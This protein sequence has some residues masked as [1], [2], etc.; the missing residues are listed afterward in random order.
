MKKLLLYLAVLLLGTFTSNAAWTLVGTDFSNSNWD[1]D[2][3]YEFTEQS[4]GVYV[5][6][7][8]S[9]GKGLT[10]QFKLR[11]G[12]DWRGANIGTKT[13]TVPIEGSDNLNVK[14]GNSTD[15]IVL[16]WYPND[17]KLDV[18]YKVSTD[19]VKL[20]IDA[21][22]VAASN[23]YLWIWGN[24]NQ[25]GDYNNR[26]S[27]QNV[28][29]GNYPY[30]GD[31]K[32]DITATYN[33]TTKLYELELAPGMNS[34][35]MTVGKDGGQQEYSGTNAIADGKVV[36]VN[37]TAQTVYDY[38]TYLTVEPDPTKTIYIDLNGRNA[39]NVYFGLYEGGNFNGTNL[40]K[41]T[42]W[43][44]KKTLKY[45]IDNASTVQLKNAGDSFA[46]VVLS[47]GRVQLTVPERITSVIFVDNGEY[48]IEGTL[49]DGQNI[50]I[51]YV[52][53]GQTKWYVH[54][55]SFNGWDVNNTGY[56]IEWNEE[57]QAYI[58]DKPEIK[59]QFKISKGSD[60]WGA[61][62][63]DVIVEDGLQITAQ[64]S[65]DKNFQVADG[66][67][68]QKVRITLV[69]TDRSPK[70]TFS[71]Y[72]EVAWPAIQPFL[73]GVQWGW[74]NGQ[75]FKKI[76]ENLY[77]LSGHSMDPNKDFC[78]DATGGNNLLT[79]ANYEGT[80]PGWLKV[81]G[82]NWH[83]EAASAAKY[84]LKIHRTAQNTYTWEIA[85]HVEIPTVIPNDG[86]VKRIFLKY[87]N[88]EQLENVGFWPYSNK[89]G[90]GLDLY[91]N[92]VDYDKATTVY[93]VD[94]LIAQHSLTNSSKDEEGNDL[95]RQRTDFLTVFTLEAD[96]E[97]YVCFELP[98]R[99]DSVIF[100]DNSQYDGDSDASCQI[101]CEANSEFDGIQYGDV[102]TLEP[103]QTYEPELPTPSYDPNESIGPKTFHV[104][105][106]GHDIENIK[107]WFY[108]SRRNENL[109]SFIEGADETSDLD[110]WNVRG[111]IAKH[112][113]ANFHSKVKFLY[114][115]D[116]NYYS[117][118][119]E[120]VNG[121]EAYKFIVP[122]RIN[123]LIM[124]DNSDGT[125]LTWHNY[126]YQNEIKGTE[127]DAAGNWICPDIKLGEILETDAPHLHPYSLADDENTV[128]GSDLVFEEGV[129]GWYVLNGVYVTPDAYKIHNWASEGDLMEDELEWAGSIDKC[130]T[131][132]E[133]YSQWI[134]DDGE[135]GFLLF[136]EG[137]YN[138]T[139][140][141]YTLEWTI[142]K[143]DPLEDH[144]GEHDFYVVTSGTSWNTTNPPYQM[145][146]EDGDGIYT[147]RR[148][149]QMTG[150]F[151]IYCKT[152]GNWYT[153]DEMLQ[154]GYWSTGELSRASNHNRE[155]VFEPRYLKNVT[156]EFDT[157]SMKV[158]VQGDRAN[159]DDTVIYFVINDETDPAIK[160]ENLHAYLYTIDDSDTTGKNWPGYGPTTDDYNATGVR[161]YEIAND[162][163]PGDHVFKVVFKNKEGKLPD[164]R[165]VFDHVIFNGG[166]K[167]S[168]NLVIVD[169]G[170]YYFDDA[171]MP[172]GYY[173]E[174]T[175]EESPAFIKYSDF[176][177]SVDPQ[178]IYVK[179]T[180]FIKGWEN[181]TSAELKTA[182][183][184]IKDTVTIN[185]TDSE[186]NHYSG[187]CGTS[188]MLYDD[189]N[190]V[191]Y[192]Y[193][194]ITSLVDKL[195][196][197]GKCKINVEIN[198]YS[199][200][201]TNSTDNKW[202]RWKEVCDNTT[203]HV[204]SDGT[205]KT[206][207]GYRYN[208]NGVSTLDE[209]DHSL[210][211]TVTGT[212]DEPGDS[213]RVL[214][215]RNVDFFDGVLYSRR[216][217]PADFIEATAPDR[218]YL[219]LRKGGASVAARKCA[220]EFAEDGEWH[221]TTDGSEGTVD[222][223]IVQGDWF[224]FV[225]EWDTDG[226]EVISKNYKATKQRTNTLRNTR[227]GVYQEGSDDAVTY[228]EWPAP[229]QLAAARTF[230][231]H[232]YWGTQEMELT[233]DA[234]T[235]GFKF[236]AHN[237]IHTR[238][239]EFEFEAVTPVLAA[240][241]K[242]GDGKYDY[243]PEEMSAIPS[244]VFGESGLDYRIHLLSDK[245]FYDALTH[246][247]AMTTAVAL[248][249][250]NSAVAE[251]E[252]YKLHKKNVKLSGKPTSFVH[253]LDDEGY[254]SSA[255][256]FCSTLA[257]VYTVSFANAAT[258]AFA[259]QTV[260]AKV[261]VRPTIE[262]LHVT[263]NGVEVK[264]SENGDNY[265][266]N[267]A[268][269][270]IWQ[271]DANNQ[272]IL[273]ENG[274]KIPWEYFEDDVLQN[275]DGTPMKWGSEHAFIDTDYVHT[276]D[277]NKIQIWFKVLKDEPAARAPRRAPAST[278]DL[279]DQGYT[280]NYGKENLNIHELVNNNTAP[281][282][283]MY[284][285]Q[286]GVVSNEARVGVTA[287][288]PTAVEEIES[289]DIAGETDAIYY[290]LQG[291]P[292]KNPS[293]GIYIKVQ[294]GKSEKVLL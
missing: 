13:G 178:Y 130:K 164:G 168:R 225:A 103:S 263:V 141:P 155:M 11:N 161:M 10:G 235:P 39:S 186:G 67:T 69:E 258:Q 28:I 239:A 215:L 84:D 166:G 152:G 122:G 106:N 285:V 101:K 62:G 86:S 112:L 160:A 210:C 1:A 252:T 280:L 23:I 202:G 157:N 276:S 251:T 256:H 53:P 19:P 204:H 30:S 18:S 208:D 68:L 284:A 90:Y 8:A 89:D 34:L 131:P 29:D 76:T 72:G 266:L 14:S 230:S 264:K 171:R 4:T 217:E 41:D 17:S 49:A 153:L 27:L 273:D 108:D 177:K 37:D 82:N 142:S 98:S 107:L 56:Q 66:V 97:K 42:N 7:L 60:Y 243:L 64:N 149:E 78:I 291:Y 87:D 43:D 113:D 100:T 262:S 269:D 290:D 111:T 162:V 135:G 132:A 58:L 233:P 283:S 237:G 200:R 138:F 228:Y 128:L 147:F 167:Q 286:N 120:D 274:E 38:D 259:K 211:Y 268:P 139:F 2:S 140:H 194:P 254:T 47:D 288:E 109:F 33:S 31:P 124:S 12:S 15:N 170:V 275:A 181:M 249:T 146:D 195:D 70:L 25:F 282:I 247:G 214:V 79:D 255:S 85:E 205:T 145:T 174:A 127:Q 40:F 148:D 265:S 253:D 229:L 220:A 126:S 73:K 119:R 271:H 102:F 294:N 114:P 292:V 134:D 154:N 196:D 54:G 75:Y 74:D 144:E 77:A 6:D 213:R 219:M 227:Y 48:K 110:L 240:G 123:S 267:F 52:A 245:D 176:D 143:V 260:S 21:N 241:A 3:T 250:S 222:A 35:I 183:S 272:P 71:S 197:E 116:E 224:Y 216:N 5:L 218:V 248:H 270:R 32:K 184:N 57:A 150:S 278:S 46:A 95:L 91:S 55:E 136:E 165:K 151:A 81:S 203:A 180:D 172:Y 192:F 59:G 201:A 83:I 175:S 93:T 163:I 277:R 133:T 24:G 125:S 289:A 118:V 238:T 121:E 188:Y 231:A 156:I 261:T 193:Y 169:N 51:F 137:Y 96:G 45:Y 281:T 105:T 94:W 182:I 88:D 99:I 61:D 26:P 159:Y 212:D 226:G 16:T 44:N 236:N 279:K 92:A 293:K 22:N 80:K 104:I 232:F 191:G 20:Y 179:A 198:P 221:F 257:G 173:F 65:G 242:L 63:F 223:N 287:N 246:F 9:M 115:T 158:K 209:M 189:F 206:D 199:D 190:G 117:V 50:K 187:I 244:D 207:D 36:K 185:I 234:K 129:N